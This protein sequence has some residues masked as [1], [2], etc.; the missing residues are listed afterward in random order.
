MT[1]PTSPESPIRAGD[2]D[3]LGRVYSE[4]GG[5]ILH[6]RETV[7]A[8]R[9]GCDIAAYGSWRIFFPKRLFHPMPGSPKGTIYLTSERLLFVRDIDVWQEVKP[10]LTP[11]G[12]PTA[13]EKRSKLS[14]LKERGARQYCEVLR[15]KLRPVRMK[16]KRM[17]L[18]FRLLSEDHRKY[19]LFVYT[20]T[21]DPSF[22][23]FLENS[24]FGRSQ[25]ASVR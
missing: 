18:H 6:S 5:P 12:L 9:K 14:K 3:G 19:E 25:P 1:N 2:I 8:Q 16:R 23:E 13:A 7:L 15:A 20:D 11:L 4:Q 22:F 24:T 17:L 21:D 10:L